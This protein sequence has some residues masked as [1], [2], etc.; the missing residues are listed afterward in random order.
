MGFDQVVEAVGQSIRERNVYFVLES[1]DILRKSG[2][3]SGIKSIVASALNIK[4]VMGATREGTICQLGQA[5][6]IN[7]ALQKMIGHIVQDAEHTE[8]K[9]LAI[10]HCNCKQRALDVQKILLEHFKVKNSII[11][12][13]SGVSTMYASEGGIIVAI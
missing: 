2:R 3:L 6:G 9:T 7:R 10:S 5:R 8:G 12:D 4:P 13:T 1:L 11:V